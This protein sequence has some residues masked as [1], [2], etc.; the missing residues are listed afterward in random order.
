ME[1]TSRVDIHRLP[2]PLAAKVDRVCD[3]FWD[4]WATGRRPRAE[5]YLSS[6]E[7]SLRTPLLAELLRV[8]IQARR[9]AGEEITEQELHER[10]PDDRTA[11]EEALQRTKSSVPTRDS[12]GLIDSAA[13]TFLSAGQSPASATPTVPGYDLLGPIGEGG[14]GEVWKARQTTLNRLVALKMVLGEQRAGSKQLIRFLA[15]ADAVAAV[16]HPHVVQVYDYGEASGRPFLAM[17]YLPGGSLADRLKRTGPLDPKAAA[18]LVATLAGAVQAA[19]DLGI[20]HRDLK[21]A[22]VLFDEHGQPKVTDFGL[23]K[24]AGRSDLTATQAVMGTPAYMA[25]E[26]ARGD[27]K[28]VGPQADVYSLGVILYECLTGSRPFGAPDPIVLL[29]QVTED[30]PERPGKRVPGLPRDV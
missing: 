23:A 20:V 16:K 9:A 24:R 1:N 22:N 8:E 26:Q 25:P 17:E 19:H 30:E 4:D 15:E 12:G 13:R 6:A 11:I 14:M 18:Q 3:Q 10:F 27:T 7:E 21:P 29:R 5:D 28:F 2:L